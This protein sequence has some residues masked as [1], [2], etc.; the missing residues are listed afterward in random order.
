MS[1]GCH[2]R[3]VSHCL[4]VQSSRTS[5]REALCGVV[6]GG[7]GPPSF[8][9]GSY[10]VID[11]NPPRVRNGCGA[12]DGLEKGA[13]RPQATRAMQCHLVPRVPPQSVGRMYS[14]PPYTRQPRVLCTQWMDGACHGRNNAGQC[15]ASG[16]QPLWKCA[17]GFTAPVRATHEPRQRRRAAWGHRGVWFTLTPPAST[18]P[19]CAFVDTRSRVFRYRPPR[20]EH[21]RVV[22]AAP[23]EWTQKHGI[24]HWPHRRG[25][26]VSLETIP[27]PHSVSFSSGLPPR[28]GSAEATAIGVFGS[29]A[30][31]ASY[32][33]TRR[34]GMTHARQHHTALCAI[35]WACGGHSKGP[36]WPC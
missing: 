31:P 6:A 14:P 16:Q 28:R 25:L 3:D 15:A 29:V 33:G 26:S 36:C 20:R 18:P 24:G 2:S 19:A 32:L 23:T 13:M 10:R 21:R 35:T 34:A 12:G 17:R 7:C 30:T 5:R 4:S 11:L 1:V 27:P 9:G 22:S 8:T